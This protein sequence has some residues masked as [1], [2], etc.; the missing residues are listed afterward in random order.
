MFYVGPDGPA[1]STAEQLIADVG[2]NPVRLGGLDR[3]DLL[4]SL[5][6][7]WFALAVEQNKGRRLAFKLLTA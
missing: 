2:L 6:R 1:Q 4:D 7:I 5:L 3:A